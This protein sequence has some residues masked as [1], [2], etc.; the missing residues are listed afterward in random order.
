MLDI[1]ITRYSHSYLFLV[2]IRFYFAVGFKKKKG[3]E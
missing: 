1:A 2:N 3:G